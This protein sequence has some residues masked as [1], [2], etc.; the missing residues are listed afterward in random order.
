[1]NINKDRSKNQG[2]TGDLESA[3]KSVILISHLSLKPHQRTRLATTDPIDSGKFEVIQFNRNVIF[4]SLWK[5]IK[6]TKNL[7]NSWTWLR[8]QI[9]AIAFAFGKCERAFYWFQ[10]VTTTYVD[11]ILFRFHLHQ[12]LDRQKADFIFV[13]EYH[14]LFKDIL[15]YLCWL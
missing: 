7:R 8:G 3:L 6:T 11:P 9:F 15:F 12:N 13:W 1:M 5:K 14:T 2:K 4:H 10:L